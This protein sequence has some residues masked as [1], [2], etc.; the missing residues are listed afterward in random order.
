MTFRSPSKIELM[1]LRLLRGGEMYGLE[2]VKASDGE[3]ARGTIYVTLGRMQEKGYVKSR[4][5]KEE[6]EA[7]LPRRI[8]QITGLGLQV[9]QASEAAHAIMMR[10]GESYA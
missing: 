4:Q 9:M 7:G 2:M 1:I 10:G 8:Y 5:E 3:L 6:T